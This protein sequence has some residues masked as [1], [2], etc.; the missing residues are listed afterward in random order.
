MADV[1]KKTPVTPDTPF[2]IGSATEEVTRDAE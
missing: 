1:E 2:F